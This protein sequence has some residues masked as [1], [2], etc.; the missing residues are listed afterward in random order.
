M[1]EGD[2]DVSLEPDEELGDVASV[3]AKIKK[4]KEELANCK[5]ERA[6]YL[7]GWQRA[8]ADFINREKELSGE[9]ARAMQV[10]EERVIR[11][12]LRVLDSFEMAFANKSAW[13]AVDKNWRHGVEYIYSQLLDVL[14]QFGITPIKALG[15][16]FDPAR[17]E[18]IGNVEVSEK[19]RDGKIA[20]IVS[21]G[22][23][24]REKVFR[25]VRVK[26][27]VYKA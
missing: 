11:E 20:E 25:P 6:E 23:L 10:G 15:E 7:A 9:F 21:P 1:D 24:L 3:A 8:K 22:Y 17:H 4:L 5:K 26:V 27:W 13:E 12:M 16:T 14:E 18:S 19:E 2:K